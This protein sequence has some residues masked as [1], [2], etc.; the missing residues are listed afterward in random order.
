MNGVRK[1]IPLRARVLPAYTGGEEIFNMVSHIVGGAV[2]VAT[3]VFCVLV[4]A[5]KG[6]VCGVLCGSVFGASMTILYTVSSIYHGLRHP[7]AKKVFQILDHC[8]IYLLIAG[9]YTPMLLCAMAKEHPVAAWINFAVVW[10]MA[11]LSMTLNAID[12]AKYKLFSMLGYLGMGWVILFTVKWMFEAIGP[13]GFA[14][15]LGGGI[16]YTV[17]VAFFV[18]GSKKRYFH[19]IFHLFVI[20][21]S[22]AHALCVMFYVL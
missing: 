17:G 19:S 10:G 18:L 9:T 5:W 1:R 22:I 12:L 8:G 2:G 4:A 21:G 6:N 15:L 20:L 13:G 11:A 7:M 16:L 14:L 3:L